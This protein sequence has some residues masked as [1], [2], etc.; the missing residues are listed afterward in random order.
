MK[1]AKMVGAALKNKFMS[2][3]VQKFIEKV[4]S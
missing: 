3:E 1:V 4:S 2:Y